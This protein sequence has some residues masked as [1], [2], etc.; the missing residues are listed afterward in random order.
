MSSAEFDMEAFHD[1]LRRNGIDPNGFANAPGEPNDSSQRANKH[2]P[3][4]PAD[5]DAA[6]RQ[7]RG[8]GLTRRDISEA[9]RVDVAIVVET[10][11]RLGL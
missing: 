3:T 4:D 1:L 7:L 9:L 10:I 11:A 5:M 6:I 8:Q 2:R